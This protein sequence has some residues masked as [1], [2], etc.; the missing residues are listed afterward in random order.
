MFLV[1]TTPRPPR[2]T[3][4]RPRRPEHHDRRLPMQV[5]AETARHTGHADRETLDGRKPA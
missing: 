1:Q 4:G 3:G 2:R 5:I